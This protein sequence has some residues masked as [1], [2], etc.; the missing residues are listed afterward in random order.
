MSEIEIIL[1]LL[2]ENKT[3]V[4]DVFLENKVLTDLL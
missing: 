4:F 2:T 3:N 1:S